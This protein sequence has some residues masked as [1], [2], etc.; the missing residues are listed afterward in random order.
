MVCG[1]GWRRFWR[2]IHQTTCDARP[3]VSGACQVR[4]KIVI[5]VTEMVL[6]AHGWGNSVI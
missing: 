2:A 4:Y 6:M 1:A 3:K 5:I